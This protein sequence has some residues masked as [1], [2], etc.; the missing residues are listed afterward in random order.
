MRSSALVLSLI[1]AL[2]C[3]VVHG[4]TIVTGTITEN[5]HWTVSG[6]PYIIQGDVWVASPWELV[7]SAGVSIEFVPGDDAYF[8]AESGSTVTLS[9]TADEPIL[10]TSASENPAPGDYGIISLASCGVNFSAQH[11]IIEYATC[12]FTANCP[13]TVV[14]VTIRNCV[15]G[16]CFAYVGGAIEG[17]RSVENINC[18][19]I[20]VELATATF[21]NC[22]FSRNGGRGV[23]SLPEWSAVGVDRCVIEDNSLDGI[24][25][26]GDVVNSTIRA[27]NGYGVLSLTGNIIAG[28]TIADNSLS[29]VAIFDVGT[30][31]AVQCTQNNFLDDDG[32]LV[33]IGATCNL[34]TID[35]THNYWGTANVDEI[36]SRIWDHNDNPGI[37]TVVTYVPFEGEVPT[38][39]TS[40]GSL[41]A[42][43]R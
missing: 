7:V 10:F 41:K 34:P 15:Q 35:A 9:G 28:N 2:R 33:E 3:G 26:T 14:D 18:G 22:E 25:A 30:S 6:S 21:R 42:L 17:F 39:R 40:W 20:G 16:L 19:A 8:G 13:V 32:L 37:P 38:S 12:G 4:E 29:E 11:C 31:E 43:Y 36:A 1:A 24:L 5:Q 23:Q 27:N